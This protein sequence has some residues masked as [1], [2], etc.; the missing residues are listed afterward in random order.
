MTWSLRLGSICVRQWIRVIR[1]RIVVDS[2]GERAGL[3]LSYLRNDGG[4]FLSLSLLLALNPKTDPLYTKN[5]HCTSSMTGGTIISGHVSGHR[6]LPPWR[7]GSGL[8]SSSGRDRTGVQVP[9][10]GDP[11]DRG[12]RSLD[13]A[14]RRYRDPG[15]LA[16]PRRARGEVAGLGADYDWEG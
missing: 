1:W 14:V 9:R 5:G 15:S 3:G 10:S 2:G 6:C 7:S 12:P 8:A 16:T 11:R 4:L 13:Q